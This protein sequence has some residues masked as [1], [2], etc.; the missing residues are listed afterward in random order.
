MILEADEIMYLLNLIRE[1]LPDKFGYS[2]DPMVARIQGKLSI[3][4]EVKHRVGS[5]G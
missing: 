5:S 4:L 2:K 3:M 1:T